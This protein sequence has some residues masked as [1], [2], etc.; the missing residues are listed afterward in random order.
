M[1]QILISPQNNINNDL[2]GLSM[3]S[4]AS[5]STRESTI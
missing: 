1:Y 3:Y 5:G 2:F 4:V